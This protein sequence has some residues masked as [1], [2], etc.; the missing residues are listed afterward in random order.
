MQCNQRILIKIPHLCCN[1]SWRLNCVVHD[2]KQWSENYETRHLSDHPQL[3]LQI[4]HW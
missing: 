3:Q 1:K 2:T 4:L